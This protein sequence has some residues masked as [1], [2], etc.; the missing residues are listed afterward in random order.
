MSVQRR[1]DSVLGLIGA[2]AIL[3]ALLVLLAKGTA[4]GTIGGVGLELVAPGCALTALVFSRGELRRHEMALT[5]LGISLVVA[6]LGALLLDGLPGSLGRTPWTMFLLAI[7]FAALTAALLLRRPRRVPGAINERAPLVVRR[8]EDEDDERA[9][10]WYLPPLMNWF[11]GVVALVLIAVAIL[12]ARDAANESPGFTELSALPVSDAGGELRL[13]V[14]VQNEEGDSVA[15]RLRI[16]GA[17]AK[18]S[19]TSFRVSAGASR[20]ILSE[21]L[22][23]RTGRVDVSLYRGS[24]PEPFLHASYDP[25]TV[26][27]PV[28]EKGR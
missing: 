27:A 10:S 19:E 11:F 26:Q 20:R 15:Y 5:A 18:P 14:H 24:A 4:A 16:V 12:V 25:S 6:A 21:A 13:R 9:P 2:G 3:C 22:G 1:L 23:E 7:T 17:G 8:F 28:A